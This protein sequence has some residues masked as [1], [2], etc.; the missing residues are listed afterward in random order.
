MKRDNTVTVKLTDEEYAFLVDYC[1]KNGMTRQA[2]LLHAL[3]YLRHENP[4]V[5]ARIEAKALFDEYAQA[6]TRAE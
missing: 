3:E 4:K 1:T 6:Q 5:R 2:S